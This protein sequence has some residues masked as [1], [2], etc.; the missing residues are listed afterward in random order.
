MPQQ[1]SLNPLFN[2]KK[3]SYGLHK[4]FMPKNKQWLLDC[5]YIS[6][7]SEYERAWLDQFNREFVEGAIK[8]GDGTALHVTDELRKA[9]YREN[10]CRT[11]DLFAI[12]QCGKAMDELTPLIRDKENESDRCEAIDDKYM[13][14]SEYEIYVSLCFS[15]EF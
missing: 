11:R 8:K 15:L 2:K 14:S 10:T 3:E 4:N 13:H 6:N 7:L 1:L 12:K 5:D 9:A